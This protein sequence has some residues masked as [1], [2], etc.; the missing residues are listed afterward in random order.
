MEYRAVD[1]TRPLEEV[2]EEINE[3]IFL[4]ES[5]KDSKMYEEAGCI[6]YEVARLIEG[7]FRHF[8]TAQEKFQESARCFL[9][10]H[11]STVYDCYQKILDL[12]MKDNKLNL[13][14]QDCF[15]FGHKFGTLYRDEEKRE[16]FF[17]RGDQIRV[18]HG[19][20][21]R[22]PKTSFDLSDYEDDVQKAFKDYD[23]FNIKK[24]LPVFGH[25]TYTSACRNCIDVY[26][27]LCDFIKE[28]QREEVEKENRDE[29]NE[30]II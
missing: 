28:K 18:E 24:D 26:G 29:N 6:Y 11:S 30:K 10:I 3:L 15:I 27:H 20:S 19:K 4:G 13:A 12:L 8:E 21:H 17:K 16:S 14:I 9:K 2:R 5:Y 22:C 25:I 23:M 1:R 7:Y